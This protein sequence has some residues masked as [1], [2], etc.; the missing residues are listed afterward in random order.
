MK[1][2]K[3][4]FITICVLTTMILTISGTTQAIPTTLVDVV[5]FPSQ[6][7]LV[8]PWNVH[9]LGNQFPQDELIE[10]DIFDSDFP[11]TPCLEN[12]DELQI[13]NPVVFIKN[14]GTRKWDEVWYVAD[15][16]TSLQN[17]DGVV[18]GG[19]AFKIDNIGWNIP[20]VFE[21]MT[22]DNIFEPGEAWLFVIQ[23]YQNSFGL[24]PSAFGSI[25][26]GGYSLGDGF[27]SGSIIA[28]PAPGAILLGG[29]GVG[30]IGWLKRRRTL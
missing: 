3:K 26:V 19:L 6:D 8:V 24:P 28:I 10:S 27:S 9:E 11:F 17:Y 5:D 21:S 4:K 25:G 18:N 16:E 7:P 22:I 12:P 15:P 23:D 14:K 20:L 13:P 30:L 1:I 29:I 2:M